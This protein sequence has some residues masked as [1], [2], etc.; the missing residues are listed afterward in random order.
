MMN[1]PQRYYEPQVMNETQ[2]QSLTR[3]REFQFNTDWYAQFIDYLDV[4]SEE[5]ETTYI[6][7]LKQFFNYLRLA[8]VVNPTRNDIVNY[9]KYLTD[10]QDQ[11]TTIQTYLSVVKL[12]FRWTYISGLYPNVADHVKGAKIDADHKRD[13]LTVDQVKHLLAVMPRETVANKRDYA[14]V[15]LM[16][17][18]G[19]RTIELHRA[20]YGDIGMV[21]GNM[22]LWVQGK[23]R[24]DKAQY[25]KLSTHVYNAIMEYLRFRGKI[26]PIQ[27]LFASVSNNSYG[28]PLTT[29]SISHLSKQAMKRAGYNS[30]R[31]TAHS[32]RHTAATLNLLNGGSLE[33]TQQLLR[34]KSITT[35]MIYNHELTR[36]KNQSEQRVDSAIFG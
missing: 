2:N 8:G 7:S 9:R 26:S 24:S 31:L 20:R 6:K 12:F 33:E 36:A 4:S 21:D 11:P 13:F 17:T 23:G 10:K 35:T 19:L 15:L 30:P 18:A 1:T 29:R 3:L 34:H 25:V 5:S 14:A 22:V 32:F 28:Q 27:P 16:I